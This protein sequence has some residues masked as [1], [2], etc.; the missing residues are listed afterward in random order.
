MLND[1]LD[2]FVCS[3]QNMA[4]IHNAI[5]GLK[6]L[7]KN[8]FPKFYKGEITPDEALKYLDLYDVW[9]NRLNIA[10]NYPNA[11]LS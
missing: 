7:D 3:I 10:Y 8:F 2:Y 9:V 11:G 5:F 4:A 6:E 1:N